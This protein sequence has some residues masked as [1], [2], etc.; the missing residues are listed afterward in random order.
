MRGRVIGSWRWLTAFARAVGIPAVEDAAARSHVAAD[1]D[2]ARMINEFLELGVPIAP[3]ALLVA[4]EM[5]P[6]IIRTL[7]N[8]TL[9][10]SVTTAV[11][12][13]MRDED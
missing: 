2:S 12:R 7:G 1:I 5:I 13:A 8:V 10:V 11:N 4:V 6:D 9:D 3:L